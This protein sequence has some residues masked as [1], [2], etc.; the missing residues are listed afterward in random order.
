MKYMRNGFTMIELAVAFFILGMLAA[1]RRSVRAD[2]TC[3]SPGVASAV[4]L[5]I[6]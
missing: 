6:N 1:V 5:C 3:R 4:I 2:G